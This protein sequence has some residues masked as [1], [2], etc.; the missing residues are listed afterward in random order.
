MIK[1]NLKVLIAKR[2]QDTGEKLTYGRLSEHTG[3]AR[4]TIR[5]LAGRESARVDLTTLDKLCKYFECEVGDILYYVPDD[6]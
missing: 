2:E 4:N 5:R 1:V 3:L 6:E